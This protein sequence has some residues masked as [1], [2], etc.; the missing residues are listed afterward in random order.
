MSSSQI[1]TRSYRSAPRLDE[2]QAPAPAHH[3]ISAT[4]GLPAGDPG[5]S[6]PPSPGLIPSH[7]PRELHVRGQER[8]FE[9]LG[10][11]PEF[12][13]AV[14]G[15][16]R[17][18]A[19]SVQ[20]VRSSLRAL[21]GSRLIILSGLALGIDAVAHEAALDSKLPTV[22]VLG[23][24]LDAIYPHENRGLAER[25][26]E[27]GG[28][29]V[30]E[31][32]PG[33]RI[34]KHS[35]LRRNRLIAGWAK[36]TWIAEAG[37]RS[38]ALNTAAWASGLSRE[39][40]ATPCFPGDP[41]HAGTQGLIQREKARLFW[42]P[43]CLSETWP[44]LATAGHPRRI[45]PVPSLW[46]SARRERASPDTGSGARAADAE[47]LSLQIRRATVQSGGASVDFLLDWA[48]S[49]QWDPQRFFEALQS[50]IAC[51]RV[52]DRNGILCSAASKR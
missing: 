29:L 14:V 52:E 44:E 43:S 51:G 25:I 8:A 4:P 10:R 42:R 7:P 49:A 18:Q 46:R 13:L 30:T 9:L 3:W 11:L 1:Q 38:G 50:A 48:L 35:F 20:L 39:V 34:E 32:G 6:L 15:T 24:P 40:Y 16:R 26:L 5:E 47:I 21:E 17:P 19:R 2:A 37:H 28:L 31:A 45:H 23:G 33:D 41:S 12:G 22:A 27:E 36:A